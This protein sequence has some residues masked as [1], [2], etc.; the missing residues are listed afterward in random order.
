MRNLRVTCEVCGAGF[1]LS[2]LNIKELTVWFDGEAITGTIVT[3]QACR[4]SYLVQL[5]NKETFELVDEQKK[6][7]RR[8]MLLERHGDT[9]HMKQINR[10]AKLDRELN[11]I[12]Q[13]LNDRYWASFDHNVDVK[14]QVDLN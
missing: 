1:T 8:K 13:C 7:Y 14:E 3:C 10:L 11:H 2:P 4:N 12:R 9:L 5:D 6:L